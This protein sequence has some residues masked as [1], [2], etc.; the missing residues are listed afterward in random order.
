MAGILNYFYRFYSSRV[1]QFFAFSK[2]PHPDSASPQWSSSIFR[3]HY[4]KIQ[5]SQPDGILT[6]LPTKTAA[7]SLPVPLAPPPLY[8]PPPSPLP[9]TVDQI[10]LKGT[11]LGYCSRRRISN[12]ISF[13]DY[14]LR[15][16]TEDSRAFKLTSHNQLATAPKIG[17][18]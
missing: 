14:P 6:H 10:P 16:H 7:A 17:H 8:Q 1:T 11:G 15:C 2:G 18:Y 3:S 4:G 9:I 5:S 12:R 13:S